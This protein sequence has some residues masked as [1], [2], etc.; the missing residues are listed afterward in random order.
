M[1][2]EHRQ[3]HHT[4]QSPE[5][6]GGQAPQK[7]IDVPSQSFPRTDTPSQARLQGGRFST[8]DPQR[9]HE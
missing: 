1:P 5:S 7:M 9:Q 8:Q 6:I 3:W 4:A 2:E